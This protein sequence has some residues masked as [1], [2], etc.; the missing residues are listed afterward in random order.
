MSCADY[1]RHVDGGNER[2]PIVSILSSPQDLKDHGITVLIKKC[3]R[4][5]VTTYM[6]LYIYI[7]IQAITRLRPNTYQVIKIFN[8]CMEHYSIV[9]V[10]LDIVI[11]TCIQGRQETQNICR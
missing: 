1:V 2:R 3:S 7:N 9:S 10:N 6:M 11:C 8:F 4:Y 5:P